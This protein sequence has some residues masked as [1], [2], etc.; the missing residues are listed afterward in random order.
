MKK[1]IIF[2]FMSMMAFAMKAENTD[3]SGMENVIYIEPCTAEAGSE[4]V[5]SVKMKNSIVAESFGFDLVLP[6]GITVAVDEYGDPIAE[7][8]TERTNDKITDHFD[9]AFKL[10]GTLN[11]QAYSSKGRTISGNEG[12]VCLITINIAAGMTPGI[13]PLL[14]KNIAISDDNSVTYTEDLVETSI[15]IISG[16][17]GRTVLDENSTTAPASA[18]NVNVRVKRTISANAWNTIVLPFDMTEAQTKEAFGDD[19]QLADFTGTEPE[20]DTDENC[21]AIVAKFSSVSAIEANHPYIIKV[22][23]PVTEF[24]AD[25]VDIDA[26][27]EEAYIEFDNGK[28]GSRRV[29]YSGFYGTY[30]AQTDLDEYTLFLSGNKFYYSDG[31]VKMK[32]YRAYFYFLDILAKYDSNAVKMLFDLDDDETG[33]EEFYNR[34]CLNDN[35]F[36]LSGRKINEV[37]QRGIYIIKGKKLIIK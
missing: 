31:S 4:Y 1:V 7:L 34:Q 11:I 35:M 30:H 19:V 13:Y 32:G 26:D 8:S 28:S 33:L 23:Q 24:T 6:D 10:D 16:G 5:M 3:I 14:I 2:T 9:A 27:E 29:V 20:F 22:S 25:N 21:V 15:E 12:E 36:D 18:T 37:P 17:D